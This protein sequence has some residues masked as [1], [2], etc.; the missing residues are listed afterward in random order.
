MGRVKG[1]KALGAR[2]EGEKR[3]ERGGGEGGARERESGGGEREREACDERE[4]D[5]EMGKKP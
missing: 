1:K 3:R 4:G 5:D 2:E